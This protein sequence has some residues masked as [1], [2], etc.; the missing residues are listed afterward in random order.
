MQKILKSYLKRLTNLT[1]TNKSL[2]LLSLLSEQFFDLHELDFLN[3]KPSFD[4]IGQLIAGKPNIHLCDALDSRF[5]KVN[6]ASTKLKK[7]DRTENF[8]EQERGAHDLYVGYPMVCG[9]LNDE[10][11]IRCPLLFFPVNLHLQNNRWVLSQRTEEPV[12]LNK[13]LLLAYAYFNQVAISDELLETSFEEFDKDSR[14]FRTQLYELLKGSPVE[15]NFNK[16]LFNDTLQTFGRFSKADFDAQQR[17]GELKLFPEA[18]LG[19]FPQAGSYLVPDYQILL[20]QQGM[21]SLE[22]FFAAEAEAFSPPIREENTFTPF[23]IDASQE[24]AV[25]TIKQGQSMVVQGPPGT[26]KSQL[27][28]NLIADYVARGKRVLLVCQKRVALDVVYQRLSAAGMADFVALVH[29]FKHDRRA[30]YDQLAQ[31]IDRMDAYREQNNS[32]DAILLERT[33]LQESRKIDRLTGE[34]DEFRQALFDDGECDVSVKDL[35]L[36]SNP[37]QAHI[38][39]T[40]QYKAF[41][42]ALVDGFLQKLAYYQPYAIQFEQPDYLWKDRVSFENFAY[43]DLNDIIRTLQEI[44]PYQKTVMQRTETICGERLSVEQMENLRTEQEMWQQLQA[45]VHNQTQ[46][47]I[48]LALLLRETNPLATDQQALINIES[49]WLRLLN[50]GVEKSIPDDE[51]D[52][53]ELVLANAQE[54]RR[55]PLKWLFWRWFNKDKE[56]VQSVLQANQ[57]SDS[58]MHLE[59]LSQRIQ[60]TKRV[61]ALATDVA[62]IR[63]VAH[64]F[65]AATVQT[66]FADQQQAIE[67]KS[68]FDSSLFLQNHPA[69]LPEDFAA[70]GQKVRQLTELWQELEAAQRKWRTYLTDSQIHLVLNDATAVDKLTHVLKEDFDSLCELDKTWAG[71]NP[72][73]QD[74]IEQLW[75]FARSQESP[76]DLVSLFQNSLRLAWIEHIERKYPVLR[77][78][79][80]LRLAQVEKELQESVRKKMQLS[81]EITLLKLREKT[82]RTVEFNRLNNQVTY[83]ELKHQTSKKRNVWQMRRLFTEF[84]NEIFQL[85]PCWMAS[86]DSVSAIFQMEKIFDLVI[87][88]EASQC[89]GERGIP[90]MYRAKQVVVT[91]DNKQLSPSDLY[92]IRFEEDTE[93]TPEL[94]VDSLLDLAAQYFPQLQLN[95]HYRSQSLELIDFSN[96]HFYKN[97]LQLLPDRHQI[98]RREPAIRYVKTEGTWQDNTNPVEADAVIELISRLTEDYPDKAVGVVTFNFKQQNLIQDKLEA[99]ALETGKPLPES[100]F[101]KNIENVQGDERDIIIFSV[102]YAPDAKG[103]MTMQFGSLNMPGGENRL[104]VAVTR[105]REQI[106]VVSSILPTQLKTDE[107]AHPGPKLFKQYLEYALRVSNGAFKPV[108]KIPRGMETNRL[109]KDKLIDLHG[110]LYKELPFADLT[111]KKDDQYESLLLTDDDL[112][113]QSLSSKDAHAYTPFLLQQKNWTFGRVYSREFW[114]DPEKVKA[115]LG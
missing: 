79:S 88:D 34:L 35:Y 40:D 91:G 110:D 100:L 60:H 61:Q 32:L 43:S 21:D 31:Q 30:V 12:T 49:E 64:P 113:Y 10:T 105:A 52:A 86:P 39:L 16:E 72:T 59:M 14:A 96:Q 19:I 58:E 107:A 75:T 18:V 115:R 66:W 63:P 27:I 92:R 114:K 22:D 74:V 46:W 73:E 50:D 3:G 99:R 6:E 78:V 108:P 38:P 47:T 51:T 33:F 97:T 2:L 45:S 13:S 70:F 26:G 25:Q 109:L 106:Y 7:I 62:T 98:N 81:Q 24:H 29:D 53:F 111:R 102:G 89:F 42:F 90:A 82:Y 95:G 112:Y 15:I 20:E 17:R 87:F 84:A 54:A 44:L 65:D 68:I 1:A 37:A 5:D 28:C 104:N 23:A 71:L 48:F 69:M 4:L 76:V 57:L 103:R 41:P 55:S 94:E 85:V 67:A 101:V 11:L 83:R 80:S 9:K 56:M 8:I 36:T 93:D 77:S